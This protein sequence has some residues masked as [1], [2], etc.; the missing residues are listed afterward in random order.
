MD[1]V[2]KLIQNSIY[3]SYSQLNIDYKG[4]F[5]YQPI[6]DEILYVGYPIFIFKNNSE[7]RWSTREESEEIYKIVIKFDLD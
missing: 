7:V 1:S 6:F 3:D 2:E 4:Y 5:V